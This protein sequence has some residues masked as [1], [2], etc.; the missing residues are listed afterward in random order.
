MHQGW[1]RNP[2]LSRRKTSVETMELEE[3]EE[4]EGENLHL[5]KMDV[6]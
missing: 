1:W 6:Q 2:G 5:Q 4:E 3:E